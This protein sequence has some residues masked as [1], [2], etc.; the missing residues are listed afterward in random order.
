MNQIYQE[1]KKL[2]NYSH[3]LNNPYQYYNQLKNLQFKY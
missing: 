1:N 3:N 2:I